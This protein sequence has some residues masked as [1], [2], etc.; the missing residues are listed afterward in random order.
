[1]KNPDFLSKA[2]LIVLLSVFAV[3]CEKDEVQQDIGSQPEIAYKL[4][5]SG[6]PHVTDLIA[7]QHI[8]VGDIIISNDQANIYV[9]Y[10]INEPGWYMKLS[11]MHI[12]EDVS[13]IPQTHKGNPKVGKFD[14][15]MEHNHAT[16][17]T[18]SVPYSWSAGTNIVVAA[19]AVVD[20]D[21]STGTLPPTSNL[22]L[23]V[24]TTPSYFTTV[25]SQGGALDGEYNGWC[26]DAGHNIFLYEPYAVNV[27]SSTGDLS[28]LGQVDHPEHLDK[29]NW[30]INQD[31]VGQMS[32]YAGTEFIPMDIQYA[33]WSLVDDNP[34]TYP[35]YPPYW[36]P[37]RLE[38]LLYMAY[39]YGEGFVPDCGDKMAVVLESYKSLSGNRPDIAQVTIIE[40]AVSEFVN[41]DYGEETAW[42][43]GNPF[44]GN[45]WA[46]YMPYTLCAY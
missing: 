13:G 21:A 1:M 10:L 30:L 28:G 19:H 46:M 31:F 29:V 3:S 44:S 16:E 45:S 17:Y 27:Y 42:G 26:I 34:P 39:T 7:G 22:Q 2:I 33:I 18:I 25:I 8:D 5:D 12:A 15:Q 41:C 35:N 40:V 9:T 37:L 4:N 6:C 24:A 23:Q 38:E 14:Y 36:D 20:Y 43:M 11:H 32:T